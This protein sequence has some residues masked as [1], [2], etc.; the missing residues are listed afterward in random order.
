MIDLVMVGEN[1][2]ELRRARGL[3]LKDLGNSKVSASQIG[4]FE[5]GQTSITVD[6]MF[7]IIDIGEI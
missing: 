1:F 6:K 5:R 4:K 2:R 3:V 7:Y